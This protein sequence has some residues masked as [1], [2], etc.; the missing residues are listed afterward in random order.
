MESYGT[1]GLSGSFSPV[2]ILVLSLGG[3]VQSQF[4]GAPDG[5]GTFRQWTAYFSIALRDQFSL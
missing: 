4:Q 2:P 5:G 1:T 3:F